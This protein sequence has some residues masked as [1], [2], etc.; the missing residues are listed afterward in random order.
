MKNEGMKMSEEIIA[1]FIIAVAAMAYSLLSM[2]VTSKY[3]KKDRVKQIQE[4]MKNINKEYADAL[5]ANDPKRLS[6]AEKEQTRIANLLKESMILQF[7][8]LVI[9]LPALLLVPMAL[10]H[11]FPNF[12]VQL[13]QPIPVVIQNLNNFPNW[14]SVFGARGW[15][16]V[17]LVF[18]SLA[19]QVLVQG[20]KK[21]KEKLNKTNL[22][23][24]KQG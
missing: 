8:P 7:K 11:F 17:S 5:K 10:V 21:L 14:R 23:I 3:G 13:S 1:F 19:I 6:K 12:V 18:T 16:W 4:E 9:M 20:T 2:Y 15:F 24:Q 22:Q